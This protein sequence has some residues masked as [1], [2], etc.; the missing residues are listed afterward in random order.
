MSQPAPIQPLD[1]VALGVMAF[2]GLIIAAMLLLGSQALPQV[3]SFSWQDKPVSADDVAFLMT[4]TQPVDPQSVEKNLQ[5]APELAGKFSWAGRRMA[6]TLA[7]SAPYGE[8]FEVKLPTATAL[9]GQPGFK[10]FVTEFQTR[11]RV[12]AYIGAEAEEEG[13][14]VLFNLTRKEKTLLT[15]EG[16]TILDFRPYPVRDRLL[17]SAIKRDEASSAAQ[18]YSV[19][20]GITERRAAPRWQF[21][22]HRKTPVAGTVE[23]VLDNKDYQNLKFDLSANGEVIV[24]Q[25]VSQANPADFG[26]WV[27]MNNEPPRKLKTEPGGDFRIAPDSLS[28]LL[29][30]GE[31]TAVIALEPN[32]TA[33]QAEQLLDFL[34]EYGLTLDIASDGS[35]AALVNF[36]QNDPDKR[37][38]QS[39]F[40]VSS[41]GEEKP[42][43]QTDG[44]ILSAQFDEKNEILYCLVNKLLPGETYQVVPYLTAVNVTNGKSQKLLEMP[45]QPE[46]TVSLAPDGLAILFDEALVSDPQAA[47]LGKKFS[48]ATSRLWLLPLFSTLEERLGG[49]PAPLM[50]TELDIAGR[51][52]TWLP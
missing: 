32:L 2:F 46:I 43:L 42:L 17:Y 8:T 19:S 6:Y 22:Q 10:P 25:R 9:N 14:L 30:Q 28:L 12:F 50:P 47:K 45:P 21:W 24:V 51:H 20:T 34:P 49:E 31:G 40:W 27:I 38:T 5:I 3:R 44:A 36:N 18:L 52:P 37:F 41:K 1:R 7:A 15:P 13:R 29:Q 23:L 4:F 35:A 26:P 33:A 16:E 11:D 48:G 39:L